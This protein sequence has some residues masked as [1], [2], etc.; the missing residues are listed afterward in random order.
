[1]GLVE[2]ERAG[3][4]SPTP[5]SV[6]GRNASFTIESPLCA[7]VK[8]DKQRTASR[9]DEGMTVSAW[10]YAN[11]GSHILLTFETCTKAYLVKLSLQRPNRSQIL[12]GRWHELPCSSCNLVHW[13][14][15]AVVVSELRQSKRDEGTENTAWSRKCSDTYMRSS[16]L[17]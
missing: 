5:R 4:L 2:I 12:A 16:N 6:R 10:E 8:T 3:L 1:M 9:F 7:F 13:V 15:L 14:I 17:S 11:F